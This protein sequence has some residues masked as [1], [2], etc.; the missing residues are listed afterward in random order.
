M[1]PRWE[2]HAC[3][4]TPSDLRHEAWTWLCGC[5]V[6]AALIALCLS[7]LYAWKAFQEAAE[8]GPYTS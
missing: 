8:E 4:Q 1:S 6:T 3:L 5:E 2:S 7:L